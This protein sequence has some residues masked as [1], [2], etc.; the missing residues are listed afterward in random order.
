MTVTLQDDVRK[1]PGASRGPAVVADVTPDVH[2]WT[3]RS[4]ETPRR[5]PRVTVMTGPPESR[6][7]Y[8]GTPGDAT[9]TP[10]RVTG[11]P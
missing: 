10:V 5:H 1:H 9:V 3:A 7:A 8:A 2:P 4:A 6:H 11:R